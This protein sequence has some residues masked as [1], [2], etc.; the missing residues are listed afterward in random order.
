MILLRRFANGC[1]AGLGMAAILQLVSL[2]GTT[3]SG[4]TYQ[5]DWQISLLWTLGCGVANV[6][7]GAIARAI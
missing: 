4:S 2:Y 1:L 6:V 7:I 3:S 5:F